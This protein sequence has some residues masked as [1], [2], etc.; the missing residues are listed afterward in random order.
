L[1]FSIDCRESVKG[2]YKFTELWVSVR[3]FSAQATHQL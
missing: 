1:R 2:L 3:F